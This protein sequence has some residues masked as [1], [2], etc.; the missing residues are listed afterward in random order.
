MVFYMA[1]KTYL[2][3]EKSICISLH[4]WQKICKS[5][6]WGCLSAV[7]QFVS[8]MT[9][10]VYAINPQNW[11]IAYQHFFISEH[12]W[13]CPA[14]N[15]CTHMF[16]SMLKSDT[17]L[18]GCHINP[19]FNVISTFGKIIFA[20][21]FLDVCVVLLCYNKHAW[22]LLNKFNLERTMTKQLYV[23]IMSNKGGGKSSCSYV[24]TIM[25]ELW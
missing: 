15:P 10:L 23:G 22:R 1:C 2:Y 3:K 18:C 13:H 6:C 25:V 24:G 9:T 5:L 21:F 17:L 19:I 7:K 8:P 4:E 16:S 20:D 11:H 12:T 14:V